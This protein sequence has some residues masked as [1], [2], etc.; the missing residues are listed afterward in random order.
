MGW[1]AGK[2]DRK[3]QVP[4]DQSKSNRQEV[5]PYKMHELVIT[6]ARV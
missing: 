1:N 4:D 2:G 5:F 6:E 3:G